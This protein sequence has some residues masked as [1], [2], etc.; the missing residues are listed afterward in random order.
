MGHVP[1]DERT[2][3]RFDHPVEFRREWEA[4]NETLEGDPK[5]KGDSDEAIHER[6]RVTLDFLVKWDS[7]P[8]EPWDTPG[9]T[10]D[11]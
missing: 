10:F 3:S 2:L 9:Q 6:L 11:A 4:L 7:P 8:S 1:L 5:F